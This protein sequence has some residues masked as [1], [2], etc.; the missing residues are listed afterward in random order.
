MTGTRRVLAVAC[1]VTFVEAILFTALAPLL[2]ELVARFDVS[3]TGAGV[4]SAAY[5]LGAL[6][7]AIPSIF[8]ARRVGLRRAVVVSL[9]VL[10]LSSVAL[11]IAASAGMVFAARFF[12]GVGSAI[13]YTGALAWLTSATS[14][15]RRAEAIGVAFSAAF[16]GALLGPLLGALAVE[17]G[18]EIVFVATAAFAGGLA[19][20][21]LLLPAPAAAE[22]V[23]PPPLTRLAGDSTAVLSVWLIAL[24]GML[25]GVF[26]VLI[27]L[28]LDEIGW[29]AVAIGLLFAVG[30]V[31]VATASPV[32][33]RFAD[34]VGREVPLRIGLG[35]AAFAAVALAFDSASWVYAALSVVSA[36]AAGIL[37]GP[38]MAL[39]ADT[40]ER[41]GYDHAA[42]FGL[43]NAA[44]SPGFAVGAALGAALAAALGDAVTFLT[45]AATCVV[46]I[47]LLS[48]QVGRVRVPT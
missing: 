5:P 44:W 20:L 10:A 11:A 40:V 45:V 28:R 9:L 7:C 8:L 2:P 37:W 21:T 17:V 12:Q 18:L 22:T 4:L 16:A 6:V 41:L 30:S 47:A 14:P 34:R 48:S 35:L 39:L 3:K 19:L 42:G 25:L 29:S 43:M 1:G 15:A 13:A 32:V 23:D 27:P 38:A 31:I 36:V 26:G 24:A 46:T 33:G